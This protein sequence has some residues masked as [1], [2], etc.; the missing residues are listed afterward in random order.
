MIWLF[1]IIIRRNASSHGV[2]NIIIIHSTY[3]TIVFTSTFLMKM[4]SNDI[5]NWAYFN[6]NNDL[7][8]FDL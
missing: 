1:M 8:S 3:Y 4:P 5:S 6:I 2:K 7:K